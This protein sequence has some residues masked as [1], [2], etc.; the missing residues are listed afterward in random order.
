MTMDLNPETKPGLGLDTPETY[1]EDKGKKDSC[2]CDCGKGGKAFMAVLIVIIIVLVAGF[3]VDRFTSVNLFGTKKAANEVGMTYNQDGYYAIFL[4]NGQVYFGKVTATNAEY[5]TLEDIYYLQV[6]E[7]LQQVA[8]AG[9][10]PQS[11]LSLVK[12]GNELHGPKDFMQVN[13]THIIFTEEL[14][15]DGKVVEAITS[16]KAGN[17][18]K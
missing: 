18:P 17:Q 3:V 6:S 13:N 12:L 5:T 1:K 4:S 15:T 14:K 9:Q 10:Q 7:A 2:S 16:Y 11:Q 8:T